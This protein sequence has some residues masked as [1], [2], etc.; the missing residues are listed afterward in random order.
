[1]LK[2]MGQSE[3]TVGLPAQREMLS[4]TQFSFPGASFVQGAARAGA[5]VVLPDLTLFGQE[6]RIDDLAA[7]SRLPSAFWRSEFV[8]AGGF[9]A[10]G[11]KNQAMWQRTAS[12]S[13]KS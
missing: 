13:T 5:L 2:G 9:M 1:M 12:T 4:M 10:Y 7:R 8:D 6:A 11:P 3:G